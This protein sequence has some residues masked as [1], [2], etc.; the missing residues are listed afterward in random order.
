M[1]PMHQMEMAVSDMPAAEDQGLPCVVSHLHI[2]P[3]KPAGNVG[4]LLGVGP[5]RLL[6]ERGDVQAHR[7]KRLFVCLFCYLFFT[8]SLR[9]CLL[10]WLGVCL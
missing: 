5:K 2:E 9:S 10:A 6:P 3:G 1:Q 8:L 7:A 4:R